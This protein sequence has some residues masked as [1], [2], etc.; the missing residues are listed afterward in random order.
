MQIGRNIRAAWM[1]ATKGYCYSDI[2]NWFDWF[3]YT[4]P[5][6]F[7]Y[8]AEHGHGYPDNERFPTPESWQNWLNE[9][10]DK[11]ISCREEEWEK[12]NEYYEDYINSFDIDWDKTKASKDEEGIYTIMWNEQPNHEEISQLYFAREKE[13]VK[14]SQE[15][16]KEV[17][18]QIAENFYTL[19]D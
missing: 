1:R 3:L 8:L 4:I 7:K 10:A 11:L 15:T 18:S 12:R 2:W 6:M 16:L 9:T 14:E 17:F 13:I 19:W 5:P